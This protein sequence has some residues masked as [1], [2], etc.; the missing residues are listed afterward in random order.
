MD[1]GRTWFETRR[2]EK[3]LFVTRALKRKQEEGEL[4]IE[5]RHNIRNVHFMCDA[6]AVNFMQLNAMAR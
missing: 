2:S 1:H 4:P 3:I 5:K 6:A